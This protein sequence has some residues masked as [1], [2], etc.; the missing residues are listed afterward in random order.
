MLLRWR[1]I[2][3]EVKAFS[4][5]CRR[6]PFS[7][8]CSGAHPVLKLPAR[9]RSSRPAGKPRDRAVTSP[10]PDNQRRELIELDIFPGFFERAVVHVCP[11]VAISADYSLHGPQNSFSQTMG[12]DHGAREGHAGRAD[13]HDVPVRRRPPPNYW[14]AVLFFRARNGTSKR[15]SITP[16]AGSMAPRAA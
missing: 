9:N 8:A 12:P 10:A 4:R 14:T 7:C 11:C 15:V 16:D 5:V 13:M 1:W 3:I 2:R 6:D